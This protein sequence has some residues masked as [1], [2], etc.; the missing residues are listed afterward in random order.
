M[1]K[2][3]VLT[4]H[5]YNLIG[6]Y[7]FEY[8]TITTFDIITYLKEFTKY[9]DITRIDDKT[10]VGSYKLNVNKTIRKYFIEI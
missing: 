10:I 4:E 6:I 2:Y 3:A 7:E 9:S 8:P 5:Q 1:K